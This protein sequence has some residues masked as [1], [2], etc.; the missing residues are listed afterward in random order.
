MCK[1]SALHH[2]WRRIS[3]DAHF[4]PT[5]L[6]VFS[7]ILVSIFLS[8]IFKFTFHGLEI[9]TEIWGR[10]WARVKKTKFSGTY[11]SQGMVRSWVRMLETCLFH[12]ISNQSLL[13]S[14]PTARAWPCDQ[15]KNWFSF[16]KWLGLSTSLSSRR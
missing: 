11:A 5:H 10:G 4:S 14:Q 15:V 13:E 16:Y 1:W 7:F 6:F 2:G 3:R 12:C 9:S 8:Q